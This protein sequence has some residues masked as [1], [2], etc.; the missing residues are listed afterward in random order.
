MAKVRIIFDLSTFFDTFSFSLLLQL[1]RILVP[2][3]KALLGTTFLTI[4][5]LEEKNFFV[6]T[7]N[8][9][10]N[11]YP[12]LERSKLEPIDLISIYILCIQYI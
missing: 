12:N 8:L 3:F 9:K 11:E 6:E 2:L 10:W 4:R 7:S 5:K 1:K